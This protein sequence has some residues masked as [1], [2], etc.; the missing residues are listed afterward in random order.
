MRKKVAILIVNYNGLKFLPGCLGS[1]FNSAEDSV[2]K[3]V[4]VV[5]N[6]SSDGSPEWIR[7]NYPQARI[8][9]KII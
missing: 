1:V 2:D 3:E 7:K 6:K 4:Y 5:D 9:G 8:S